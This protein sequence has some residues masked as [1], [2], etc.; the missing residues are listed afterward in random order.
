MSFDG[1]INDVSNLFALPG[2]GYRDQ[3]QPASWKG[4]SFF[5]TGS[6]GRFGRR[7]AIHEYPNRDDVW[8]EDLGRSKR[9]FRLR[10]FL[11]GDD[12]IQQSKK[13]V[14]VCESKDET[15]E[16]GELV[17]PIFGKLQ[18]ALVDFSI[19]HNV[20]GRYAE[21]E[22]AFIASSKRIYPVSEQSSTDLVGTAAD[23]LD[24]SASQSFGKRV[25]SALQQG[26]A[27]VGK[28]VQVVQQYGGLVFRLVNDATSL[29]RTV[30][31]LPGTFGR[32]FAGAT[33]SFRNLGRVLGIGNPSVTIATLTDQGAED[34]AAVT[35]A[36]NTAQSG[37]SSLSTATA[38]SFATQT[39]AV[40]KSL[41]ASV[42]DPG[43]QVRLFTTLA[44]FAP[45]TLP[46]STAIVQGQ[47]ATVDLWRRAALTALARASALYQPSSYD[48]AATLRA[49]IIALLDAEIGIA[50]DQ[51]EDA[52]FLALLGLK[53]AVANDLTARGA[54][55]AP[56]IQVNFAS[57]M[58]ASLLAMMLYQD[59]TRA[60]ELIAESNVRNPLFM[61]TSFKALAS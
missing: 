50:G 43:D 46:G 27:A 5:V 13:L 52:V 24:L 12:V 54:S 60:D 30:Q 19:T 16:G 57:P 20:E 18:L 48:D 38:K 53:T 3:L 25:V 6:H 61:P 11:L 41:A 23:S 39:Q 4:V 29:V 8:V 58:P 59:P 44:S 55:L 15:D 10:G 28:V 33:A 47:T 31:S 26:Q 9:I 42:S 51:G 37:A 22:F 1:L 7:N 56:M 14:S 32:F 40:M 45:T 34:R 17:H 49:L 21:I 2:T 36:M 35:T